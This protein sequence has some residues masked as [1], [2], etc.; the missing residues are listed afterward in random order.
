MR[1][2][3]RWRTAWGHENER[4]GRA[5]GDHL[6]VSRGPP[7]A[8]EAAEVIEVIEGLPDGVVGFEAVGEVTAEDY[9]SVVFPAIDRALEGR[10]R[11][12]LV[13]VLGER[14]EGHTAGAVWEDNKL[15]LT[16]VRSFER[17]AVVTDLE[18]VRDLV[19]GAGWAIPGELKLFSNAERAEAIAW[20]SEG[21]EGAS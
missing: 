2:S 3:T 12:R 14:L 10:D 8:L 18:T 9:E 20:I 4:R 5:P 6:V 7:Y 1:R 16:H 11:I 19:K 17:I 21:L 15:G 13:H